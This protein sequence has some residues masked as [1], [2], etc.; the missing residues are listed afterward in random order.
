MAPSV[1]EIPEAHPAPITI[2][3][4][5][6][7]EKTEQSTEAKPKVRRIIDEEGGK[8]TASVCQLNFLFELS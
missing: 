7:S 5:T 4:K 3:I 1:A 8:T 2:P 6:I